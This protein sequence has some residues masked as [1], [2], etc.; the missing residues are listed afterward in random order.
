[1][2][3]VIIM[4]KGWLIR[5]TNHKGKHKKKE[6]KI[7]SGRERTSEIIRGNVFGSTSLDYV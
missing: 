4:K 2:A 1:M 5:N 6:K 7:K 3:M